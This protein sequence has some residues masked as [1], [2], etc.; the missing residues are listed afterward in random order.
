MSDNSDQ[1]RDAGTWAEPVKVLAVDVAQCLRFYSRLPLPALPWEAEP[2]A[3]PDFRRMA[4]V[5]PVASLVLGLPSALCLVLGLALG[6]GPWLSAG[7]AVAVATITTGAFHEDGLADTA[8][9]FGGGMTRERR[10]AI[11]KDSLIGSFGASALILA[12]A[13]RI[14]TLATVAERIEPR[15]AAAVMIAAV[16]SRTAGLATLAYLPPARLEGASYAVGRPGR[17]KFRTAVA[18]AVLL[19]VLIGAAT[20]LPVLGLAFA[21]ILPGLCAFALSRLSWRLIGGQ[22]GDVAGAIQ[23]ISEIAAMIGL[24]IALEP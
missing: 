14:G 6:F 10:L 19:I 9:G 16:V 7:L 11:M 20:A 3:L 2:H 22:T 5:L 24:L 21:L 23:Q 1:H 15:A 8:D 17:D 18:I 4:P 13:L 12:F